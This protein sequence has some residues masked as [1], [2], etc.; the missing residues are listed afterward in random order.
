MVEAFR[1]CPTCPE[2]KKKVDQIY[3]AILGAD[4]TGLNGG[5]VK[6]ITDLQ[7]C[8]RVQSSWVSNFKPVILSAV[9]SVVSI[10]VTLLV[11]HPW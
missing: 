6:A 4:G 2:L 1:D 9:T 7:K 10:V 8:G 11:T 5:I 3:L